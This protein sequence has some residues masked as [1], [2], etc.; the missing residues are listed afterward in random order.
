MIAKLKPVLFVLSLVPLLYLGWALYAN[1]LGANPVEEIT[2]ATGEWTL[3]FLMA[4]LI[5]TPL[6]RTFGLS[7][8]IKYRKMFGLFAFFYGFVHLMIWLG[9]DKSFSVAEMWK[10]TV[11]K[12]FITAGMLGF[13]LMI[14][15]AITST[16]WWIRKLKKNWATLH[17][18]IYVTCVAGVIHYLF[19]VKS[20]IEEP[21]L[22][23]GVFVVLFVWRWFATDLG[24]W[25]KARYARS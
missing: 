7:D 14:P 8:L 24:H 22:Y 25:V 23:G 6:R 2:H 18:L 15:L 16:N 9:L 10:D 17:K 21:L 20:D 5:I 3:R 12:P 11:K 13:A 19:L 1:Q 4:T